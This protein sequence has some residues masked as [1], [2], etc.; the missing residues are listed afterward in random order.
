M[1]ETYL[2]EKQH[3]ANPVRVKW[4]FDVEPGP[5]LLM[6]WHLKKLN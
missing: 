3:H 5:D 1:L 2:A 4:G 6:L